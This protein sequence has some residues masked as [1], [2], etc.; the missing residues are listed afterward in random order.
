[1]ICP[2]YEG[3]QERNSQKSFQIVLKNGNFS[4]ISLASKEAH[5]HVCIFVRLF[6]KI[7]AYKAL[8][9]FASVRSNADEHGTDFPA[10]S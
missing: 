9:D 4:E 10:E 5:T 6:V 3:A 2:Y 8:W 7:E 1:M